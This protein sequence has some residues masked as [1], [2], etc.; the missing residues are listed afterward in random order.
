MI[1]PLRTVH[2]QVFLLLT[3]ALPLLFVAGIRARHWVLTPKPESG[4]RALAAPKTRKELA[5]TAARGEGRP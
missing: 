3:L 2:R 5:A 4:Q 1:Q